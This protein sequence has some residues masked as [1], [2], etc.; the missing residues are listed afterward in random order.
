LA[1]WKAR[2]ER[3]G[4]RL[5][6]GIDDGFTGARYVR[7]RFARDCP[8]VPLVEPLEGACAVAAEL[9]LSSS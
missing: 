8:G 6:I 4:A 5:V 9:A 7:H 1:E 2:H 3:D